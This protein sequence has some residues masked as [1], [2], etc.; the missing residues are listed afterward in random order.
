M[1]QRSVISLVCLLAAACSKPPPPAPVEAV[2]TTWQL[3]A[4]GLPSALLSID[5]ASA[6]DVYAVGSDKGDGPLVLHFDGAGWKQLETGSKG[7]LW[8]VHAFP[9][10]SALMSGASATVLRLSQG[11]FERLPTPG[12]GKQTVYGVW[13]A[14]PDDFYAV[15]SAAGRDG[16][17]WHYHDRA[18]EEERLP[19]N[20]PRVA[21]DEVPGFFKVWGQGDEVWVVGAGGAILHRHGKA[22]FARVPSGTTETLF[23]VH[24]AN[25]R[26]VTVGGGSNGVALEGESAAAPRGFHAVT[27]AGAPLIQGIYTVHEGGTEFDWASGERGLIYTRPG[28]G[29]FQVTPHELSIPAASSLHAIF[30]DPSHGVWSVGGNVL[31][32]ALDGGILVHFGAPVPAVKLPPAKMAV[33]TDAGAPAVCARVV[34]DAGKGKS[35]ARR[36]DEQALAAIRLDIPRPT[37]HARN[38]LHTSAAMWDAWAAYD[39]AAAGV[40]VRER[41]AADD[42]EAARRAAISYAAYRVLS[43]RYERAVGGPTTLACLR[44]VMT[45]LGYDPADTHDAGDDPVALGNRIARQVLAATAHDGS[46]EELAYVDPKPFS[47]P[48]A[49]LVYDTPGTT[50]VDPNVWQPLNLSVAATQNGIVLPAGVQVYIGSQWGGVKPFAMERPSP[51]VPWHDAGP[52]PRVGAD[53]KRWL[54]EVIDKSSAGDPDDGRT[55]DISPG[56]FGNNSLGANDGTGWKKN[57]VTG[58]PYAPQVVPRAD[59]ARVMAE[60]WADGPN[61]ETPP[62]HWNV[63]AN[64]VSD[65]PRFTRKLFGKGEPLDPLAWD[66]HVY[67]ALNGAVHDAAIAAWDLKR[68]DVSSRPIC[69]I[70]WMGAKGQSSDSARAVVRPGRAPAGPGAHRGGH[71]GEQRARP[72]ARAPRVLRRAGRRA[73]LAWRAWRPV[74]PALGR[75]VGARRRLGPLP[76][77]ELRHAGVPGLHLGTQHLQPRGG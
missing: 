64:A 13:G 5:G 68:R 12:L 46:D 38:L 57:P 50:M 34:I 40:F 48:N 43:H 36:W 61:S 29:P 60:F 59:F 6:T 22:P 69:L 41:H 24:G 53:M 15:G 19:L 47:S 32:P 27:P 52:V 55:I 54:V 37:V 71:E 17:V 73:R 14:T 16:F 49:P 28:R 75:A 9:D 44:A 1:S 66:V 35:V 77:E 8:W 7:D 23:T 30:V 62:G 63:L 51:S 56:A 25:G 3:V 39:R 21:H 10:G 67:L 31:T 18:F 45:D 26:V 42:V 65:S 72:A 74:T 2:E 58:E 4:T 76:A 11:R 20:L 70:R 33:G